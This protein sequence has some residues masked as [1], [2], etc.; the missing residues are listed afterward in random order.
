MIKRLKGLDFTLIDAV[1]GNN[2]ALF[3]KIECNK[4][5]NKYEIAN[6]SSHIKS[7]NLF[8]KSDHLYCCI[9]EDDILISD[10]F[11]SLISSVSNWIPKNT[12]AIKLE[13]WRQRKLWISRKFISIKWGKLNFLKSLHFGTGAYIVS[14]DGAE[15]I[16]AELSKYHEPTDHVIFKTLIN[17]Q[18]NSYIYQLNPACCIQKHH[19]E[20]EK[21]DI[22]INN[23]NLIKKRSLLNKI[24]IELSR[25]WKLCIDRVKRYNQ[26]KML[27]E[28]K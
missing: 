7:L 22:Q 20:D 26:K 24:F 11:F 12:L 13:T 18:K 28:F 1:D 17:N 10:R 27:I 19:F 25:P 8:I 2:N 3:E 14:R 9:L 4:N 6:I 21:S 5:L 15:C 16:I 23:L